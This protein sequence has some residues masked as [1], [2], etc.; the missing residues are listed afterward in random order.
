MVSPA[1][2]RAAERVL[3]LGRFAGRSGRIRFLPYPGS[4]WTSARDLPAP[5]PETFRQ[6][7]KRTRGAG[8]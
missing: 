7:W 3:G 6:W 5:P 8:S 2:F 1:R 4:G